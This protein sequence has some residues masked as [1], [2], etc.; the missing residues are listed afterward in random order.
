M[1]CPTSRSTPRMGCGNFARRSRQP[2]SRSMRRPVAA[3]LSTLMRCP[4]CPKPDF[5]QHHTQSLGKGCFYSCENNSY[6][7]KYN[8]SAPST[9][10]AAAATTL[11]HCCYY[12]T[13]YYCYYHDDD[14]F[15]YLLLL[16]R[17]RY[18]YCYD[19]TSLRKLPLAPTMILLA[20]V[21]EHALDVSVRSES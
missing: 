15:Y 11:L 19:T 17:Y 13:Y 1:G 14:Y 12:T 3:A 2:S 6:N 7:F 8:Y 5:R 18:R 21:T 4:A 9:T 20:S 10:A 16:F